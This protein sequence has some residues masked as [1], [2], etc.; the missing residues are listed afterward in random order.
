MRVRAPRLA[1]VPG[2]RPVLE[3]HL[4]LETG[5]KC[6][7]IFPGAETDRINSLGRGLAGSNPTNSPRAET[8]MGNN[9]LFHERTVWSTLTNRL[10]TG[11]CRPATSGATTE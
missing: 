5:K 4:H 7:R 11:D 10:E 9:R 1:Q 3:T 6:G 8:E 2:Q